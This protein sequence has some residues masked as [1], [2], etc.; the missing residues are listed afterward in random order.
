MEEMKVQFNFI[1][2]ENCIYYDMT[3]DFFSMAK[4]LF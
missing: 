2:V 1:F 4:N 3:Y